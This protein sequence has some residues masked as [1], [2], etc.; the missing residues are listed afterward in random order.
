MLYISY[1]YT[2]PSESISHFSTLDGSLHIGLQLYN[3]VPSLLANLSSDC[4]SFDKVQFISKY[5]SYMLEH[6]LN[7]LNTC[8]KVG[9]LTAYHMNE[10]TSLKDF[11]LSSI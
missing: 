8:N 2:V 4:I 7:C 11:L 6:N 3:Q 10:F 9:L 1:F 5:D